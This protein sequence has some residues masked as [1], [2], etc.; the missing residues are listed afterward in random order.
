MKYTEIS[1]K[2]NMLISIRFINCSAL[3][4]FY[5]FINDVFLDFINYYFF[6]FKLYTCNQIKH[7]PSG[8]VNN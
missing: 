2:Y 5:T 6:S 3:I 4:I 8:V 1:S 7:I